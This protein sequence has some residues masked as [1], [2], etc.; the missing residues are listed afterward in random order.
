MNLHRANSH[1]VEIPWI[2]DIPSHWEVKKLGYIARLKSGENITSESILE[3]DLFPVY[4]G[5]GLRGYFSQYTHN[6]YHILI[7]R[8]GALCGNIRYAKGKFWAS[9]HAI[10][11]SPMVK[12]ETVWLGELLRAINLNQYSVSAA[13]PGLSVENISSIRIPFPTLEEQKAIATFLD[14]KTAAIDT[15]IAKKQRLIELL[16]EKRAALI[17]QAVTKGLNPD[18]PMKDSGIPW[19]GEIPE[20]WNFIPLGLCL[21][22]ITYGFTSPME[23]TDE[24]PY[25]LTA[26]DIKNGYVDYKNSRHTKLEE[27]EKLTGKCKPIKGDILLTK[28]GTLGRLAIADGT[29]CCINQSVALIRNGNKYLT[30]QFMYYMLRSRAYQD[31]MLFEAGGSTIKHIYITRVTKMRAVVPPEK[32]Q[33]DICHRARE[34]DIHYNKLIKR[35]SLQI[36]KLQEYRQSLITAAVTGKLRSQ[37]PDL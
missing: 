20:H 25:M 5:N 35:V 24:G 37:L 6:G 1:N 18:V 26:N 11:V 9:E 31:W 30:T 3:N 2:E 4:G 28:D 12:Y 33:D 27:V 23:A 17:N 29:T 10:V 14:R 7:G 22:L 32:E 21:K 13:Q 19:I 15:L 8:Q 16:E 36:Q 34:I